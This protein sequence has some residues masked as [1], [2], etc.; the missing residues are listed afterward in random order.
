MHDR[1][2]STVLRFYGTDPVRGLTF[3]EARQRLRRYGPNEIAPMR[4]ASP[5]RTFGKQFTSILMLILFFAAFVS[6]FLGEVLDAAVVLLVVVASGVLGFFQEYQAEKS[7]VALKKMTGPR[8]L[9][10]RE[11]KKRRIPVEKLVPGDLLILEAGDKVPADCR[12]LEGSGL[13]CVEAALTG[14]PVSVLKNP[15][16]VLPSETPLVERV[17]LAFAGTVVVKGQGKG[18][19]VATGKRTELGK[20]AGMVE[21][22]APPPTPLEQRLAKVGKVLGISCILIVAFITGLEVFWRH[23]P[24]WGMLIWGVSL[25]VAAVPET[26]PAV[27]TGTLSLGVQRMAKNKAVVR[28]LPAVETLGCTTVICTDKTGTLT[29]NEVVVREAFAGGKLFEFREKEGY[30]QQ[31]KKVEE[32][33]LSLLLRAAVLCNNASFSGKENETEILGDPVE[34]ALLISASKAGVKISALRDEASRL[35]EFPF[36]A[37]Q[38]YMATVHREGTQEI[39]YLKG[40]PEV[41]LGQACFFLQG[42]ESLPLTPAVRRELLGVSEDMACRGLR[43]L[44]FA[45]GIKKRAKPGAEAGNFFACGELTF[46][47]LI[48]LLDPPREEVKEAILQCRQAG[49]RLVMITGDHKLTALAVG[50]ELGQVLSPPG[51]KRKTEVLTGK[52]LEKLGEEGLYR[53]VE[54]V[55]IYARVSPAHKLWIVRAWQKKKQIVAMT[56]DGVNDAPALK[57]A[58]VGVAMGI[59]GTEVAKEAADIVLLDDN[60]ATIVRAIEEGRRIFSNIKKY[61]LFL[62]S[63]NM[64]EIFVCFLAALFDWALPL[65]PIHLLWI[66]LMTDGLPALALGVDPPDPD[67]MK[68]PPRRPEEGIFTRRLTLLILCIGSW[69]T[70]FLLPLFFWYWQ[71]GGPGGIGQGLW[72]ARKRG[73]LPADFFLLKAQ[74]MCLVTFILFKLFGAYNSRHDTLSLF[75]IGWYKNSWLNLAVASSLALTLLVLYH[76][77]L[78]YAFHLVPLGLADWLVAVT[79]G[80]T[81][82]VFGDVLKSFLRLARHFLIFKVRTLE[83]GER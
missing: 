30:T 4:R 80:S 56:G 41:V 17:N 69:M 14:E 32:K 11:G 50:K 52:E 3:S 23:Q 66:N 53:Q 2:V 67:L 46:L 68:R 22:I 9:A 10:V 5:W 25:A 45:S 27:V 40:A 18:I 38:K 33:G 70:L 71:R 8:A 29:R 64:A 6:F 74:T 61:L 82:I 79:A 47:G 31:G 7:L 28:H 42:G 12:L 35:W 43:V 78:N 48:G 37:V 1:E 83:G 34:K 26:L 19:V 65:L 73:M 63:T 60:F 44:G 49:I 54:E 57:K 62:L 39:V 75:R 55:V 20:I 59:A 58:D 51:G 13:E 36:D 24:F 15:L 21:E 72:E 16:A 76:P 81:I 77:A